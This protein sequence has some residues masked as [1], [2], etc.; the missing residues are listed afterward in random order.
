MEGHRWFDLIRTGRTLAVLG[1]KDF[2]KLRLP[3][4]QQELLVNPTLTQNDGY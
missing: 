3:I 2:S 4:P 1:I